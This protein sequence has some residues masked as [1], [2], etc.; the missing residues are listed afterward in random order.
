M[1]LYVYEADFFVCFLL[2]GNCIMSGI[3]FRIYLKILNSSLSKYVKWLFFHEESI[4]EEN[5]FIPL[6]RFLKLFH[7]HFRWN[8]SKRNFKALNCQRIQMKH[9]NRVCIFPL[10]FLLVLQKRFY[11]FFMRLNRFIYFVIKPHS[12]E[13]YN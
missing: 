5:V 1:Q 6:T 10:V 3:I 8:G 7:L 9:H 13:L 2:N 4:W 12:V 11:S